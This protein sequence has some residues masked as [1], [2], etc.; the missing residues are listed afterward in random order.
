M[1]SERVSQQAF[2]GV[3]ALLFAASAAV[4]ITWCA[5][6]PA[7]DGM[8][9]S[10]ESAMSMVW[11]RMPGQTWSGTAASFVG[12]WIVM[13]MAMMLPSLVP[14]LWRYRTTLAFAGE[15]RLGRFTVLAGAGYFLAWS[16]FGVGAFVLGTALTTAAMQ[17]PA[18]ARAA[19]FG[20]GTV[21][22]SAGALQFSAWKARHLVCCRPS[23]GCACAPEDV[24]A[25]WQYGMRLGMHCGCCCAGL[26][27]V[28]LV[29]GIMD[30]CAMAWVT[31]AITAER[32][33]PAGERVARATGFALVGIG[34]L[35]LARAGG[36]A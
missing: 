19:P 36:L 15:T 10:G 35:L 29:V 26:T 8:P 12:M 25:A 20:A 34:V 32:L 2:L 1:F 23:A 24:A 27:A 6:T 16:L 31:V 11:M 33:A 21:V 5:S 13:M 9:T 30:L 28:L 7:M 17:W 3:S 18:F 22:L 14:M 4:T